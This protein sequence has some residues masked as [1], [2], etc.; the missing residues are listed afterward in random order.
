[1]TK[2]RSVPLLKEHRVTKLVQALRCMDQHPYDRDKQRACIL[3]LYPDKKEKSVFRGMV[4]PTLRHLGLIVG[5]GDVI[6][7]SSNGKI[8]AKAA[9][10]GEKEVERVASV[11]FLERDRKSFHFFD[12]LKHDTY[13]TRDRFVD[14]VSQTSEGLP[15]RRI[16]ERVDSWL[17]ILKECKLIEYKGKRII[18]SQDTYKRAAGQ[19]DIMPKRRLFK[20][21]LFK[22]YES[23]PLHNT[24]GIVDISLLRASVAGQ[25]YEKHN[26]VLT[27]SQFDEILRG[28]PLVTDDYV[29]SLGQSM[30]AEQQLFNYDGKYYRTLS[31]TF[32]GSGADHEAL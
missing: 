5:F 26:M 12:C 9:T 32:F 31:I 6:R 23:L 28:I 7:L 19:L 15:R 30:G 10:K 16:E 11:V 4:I 22:Q 20:T 13:I 29:I 1:M 2:Y 8:I 17:D 3:Q 21:I 14:F 18:V 24:A 25:Y 27:E